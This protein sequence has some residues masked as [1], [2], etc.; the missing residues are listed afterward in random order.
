MHVPRPSF[1]NR[2]VSS[3]TGKKA[4]LFTKLLLGGIGIVAIGVVI[5]ESLTGALSTTCQS[6]PLDPLCIPGYAVRTL[7]RMTIAYAFALAFALA[8]GIATAM[9]HRASHVL[10]PLLD[11]FQ[12]VPVLGVVPVVFLIILGTGSNPPVF[13][14]EVASIILIFTAMAWAPTFGVIAGINAIPTDIKEAAHAYGMHGTRYLRQIVL[15]AVFPEL[16]WSSILAWGGGWY[17]IPV[18][19]HLSFGSPPNITQVD[20]PGIGRY[21]ALASLQANLALAL[22]GLVVLVGIIF[23]IDRL[24][25][26]PLGTRAERYKY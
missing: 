9:S 20:L 19:E 16:V 24:V 4:S 5:T 7:T 21:I 25:W 26:K 15:P 22:F 8:Y 18:E 10:L 23:A 11:I 12:S 2:L 14:Q 13:N 6:N 1:R 3:S 17:L